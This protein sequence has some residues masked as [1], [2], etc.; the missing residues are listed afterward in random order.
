MGLGEFLGTCN[1]EVRGRLSG[2]RW[3]IARFALGRE[4]LERRGTYRASR[5]AC[6]R[7]GPTTSQPIHL[8]EFAII[9]SARQ[10]RLLARERRTSAVLRDRG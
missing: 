8:R 7:D 4:G 9:E 3:Q 1:R 5:N 10:G 2:R 6:F